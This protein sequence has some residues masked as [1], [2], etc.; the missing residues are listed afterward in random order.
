M[1]DI[2]DKVKHVLSQGQ[3]RNHHCHWPG[4]KVQVPP[5]KWGCLKHWY[6]LPR[7][8]RNRIWETYRI[9]QEVNM[10]P[11]REYMEVALE[12]QRWI[13]ENHG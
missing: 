6:M 13:K 11:S 9:G 10:T 7:V 3:S 12:V 4:C 1:T 5:A 8:L 2:S